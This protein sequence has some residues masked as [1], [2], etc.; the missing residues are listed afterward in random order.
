MTKEFEKGREYE[1]ISYY[2]SFHK[3]LGWACL[4]MA[5]IW[6]FFSVWDFNTKIYGWGALTIFGCLALWLGYSEAKELEKIKK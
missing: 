4:V 1:R 5:P 6:Y 2:I 3:Y